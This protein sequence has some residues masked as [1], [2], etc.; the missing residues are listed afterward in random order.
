MFRYFESKK[1]K[2]VNG[3]PT[4]HLLHRNILTKLIPYSDNGFSGLSRHSPKDK[5][6]IVDTDVLNEHYTELTESEF[7]IK[8]ITYI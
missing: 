4:L 3:H 2:Y 6:K 8:E 7:F 1:S 5:G